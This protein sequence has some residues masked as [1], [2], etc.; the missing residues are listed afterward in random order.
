MPGWWFCK[1]FQANY[2]I[3]QTDR[4]LWWQ[5][6]CS[7]NPESTARYTGGSC[8]AGGREAEVGFAITSSRFARTLLVCLDVANQS[9]IYT[10][11]DLIPAINQQVRGLSIQ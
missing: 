9:P 11:Y 6:Q 4:Y 2:R 3:F 8:E 5:I 7:V 10:Y 1:L